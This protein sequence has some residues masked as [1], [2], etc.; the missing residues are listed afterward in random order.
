MVD[1]NFRK[2]IDEA[3]WPGAKTFLAQDGEKCLWN[4]KC[5]STM[6]RNGISVLKEF[7][8]SSQDL[9]AI[10]VAWR[11]LE[12]R[13]LETQPASLETR[14]SFIGRLRNGVAWVNKNRA[15]KFLRL[16]QGQKVR[17][18]EVIEMKGAR[19]KGEPNNGED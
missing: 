12:T 2:W 16:C 15:D 13:L 17:A 6:N 4:D 3:F 1:Q 5:I 19:I 11:E 14:E 7:P 10:E 9:D 18:R 8:K